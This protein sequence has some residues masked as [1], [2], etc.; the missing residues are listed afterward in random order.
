MELDTPVVKRISLARY[1][2]QLAEQESRSASD[3]ALF[4]GVNLLQD[5]VEMF[6]V[7]LSD[8]LNAG[9]KQNTK[10]EEYFDLINEKI[11]PKELPFRNRLLRLNR[12]RVD[13]KHYGIQPERQECGGIFV[14]AREFFEET[15][16][17]I[18][19]INFFTISLVDLLD[20]KETKELLKDAER[21]LLEHHYE[22]CLINCRKAIFLEIEWSYDIAPFRDT[23]RFSG[24][25]LL[26]GPFSDA[27][28]LARNKEYIAENVRDPTDF[29][30]YDHKALDQELLKNGVDNTAFWNV[31]RLTPEVYRA[32]EGKAW[33]IKH[34]YGKFEEEGLK[35]RAEYV[36][37][38]TVNIVRAI[39]SNKRTV[40]IGGHDFYFLNLKREGVSVYSKADR[41]SE[42][43][44]TTFQGRK[45]VPCYFLVTG[46][47]GEKYYFVSDSVK[48][49]GSLGGYIHSDD[50]ES[51]GGKISPSEWNYFFQYLIDKDE[52]EGG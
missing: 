6:L 23:E 50:V 4:S 15:A 22:E 51:F 35:E 7:A 49:I 48:G 1:L 9:I 30:V 38:T 27:P 13:S 10:F 44:G 45:K 17:S 42:V 37:N 25:S 16:T 11:K 32:K 26:L 3:L 21:Y 20:E 14:S 43:Y 33:I 19:G 12:I 46:L 2:F 39:H 40:R 41:A 34:E 5:S 47:D 31:W 24:S 52:K 29:V 28:F 8:Q 18:L 36:F